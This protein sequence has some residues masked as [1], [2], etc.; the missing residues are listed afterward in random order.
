MTPIHFFKATGL[1]ALHNFFLT[2]ASP[3][4]LAV[5][6]IGV[7]AMLLIQAFF[8][9]QYF[10]YFWAPR[11]FVQKEISS[12]LTDPTLP[13]LNWAIDAMSHLGVDANT[14]L[15]GLAIL[16]VISLIFLLCGS[17][18]RVF[19]FGAWFLHWS[20]ANTGYSGAYGADMYAHFFLFYLMCI[21]CA[22]AFSLDRILRRVSGEPS[23][24]ARLSLRVLQLHMCISYFASGIEKSLGEAW[25]NGD[26]IWGSLTTPG[27]SVADFHWLAEV[28]ILPMVA[29]WVVLAIEI[30][31]CFLIWPRK[32][33]VWW[34]MG[35]CALHLGI[36]IFLNLPIFGLLMCVPTVALFGVSAKPR[37]ASESSLE[38][39]LAKVQAII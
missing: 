32:T 11:G 9:R 24:Q 12:T 1:P 27:Y 21:P 7:S 15:T 37:P 6:R 22:E 25:W 38:N 14:T 10:L 4:P 16:Y 18:T 23:W 36:A 31:Y 17:F 20:F 39:G 34:I 8:M 5:M 2:P 26:M 35:T 28:P 30:F 19:A 29:G 13:R 3:R 33:R